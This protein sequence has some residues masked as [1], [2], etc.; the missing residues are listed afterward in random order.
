MAQELLPAQKRVFKGLPDVTIEDSMA[1]QG[2]GSVSY[3]AERFRQYY[4]RG[5]ERVRK[6]PE[7]K[8]RE[9]GF[10]H[11][12]GRTMFRHIAFDDDRQLRHHLVDNAPAH[13]YYSS[14]YYAAPEAEMEWK[15]WLGADLVFDIDADHIDSPCKEDHD[16]WRCKACGEKGAGKAPE[17]CPQ[18]GKA[19][20]EEDIWLCGK[21]LELAKFEANKL[22]DIMIQ[23]FGFSSEE[24]EVNFSGN[25]GYH[26]HVRSGHVKGLNQLARREIVDYIMGTGINPRYQGFRRVHRGP[27]TIAESGWRGRSVKALYGYINNAT[28]EAI[29]ALKLGRKATKNL[30]EKRD[31]IAALLMERHPSAIL[32][33]INPKSLDR[34]MEAAVKSQASAIDTVVTTDVHRLI[35]LPNTLHGKTGF[36]AQPVA[37][38]ELEDY[39]PLSRSVALT[40]GT[41]RV[42]VRWAPRFR[43]GDETYG[44]FEEEKVELPLAAAVFLLSKKAARLER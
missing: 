13:V 10:L 12:E 37:F 39:D 25:R 24:L 38:D 19:T 18:C 8:Q 21:C 31:E 33:Y 27:S 17:R 5:A 44:P 35:R 15:G 3:V 1:E 34:L 30:I 41:E 20:F 43:I 14:A 2:W 22:I 29:K 28:P 32:R 40:G 16:R 42:H 23:D 6:P 26:L 7:I 4:L 9:F 36:L 11:F